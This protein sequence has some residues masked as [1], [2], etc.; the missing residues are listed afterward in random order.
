M[1]ISSLLWT[2]FV[3][4]PLSLKLC[5]QCVIQGRVVE[6]GTHDELIAKQG[7]YYALVNQQMMMT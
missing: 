2:M 4:I 3:E 5:S 6:Q 1:L 7:A